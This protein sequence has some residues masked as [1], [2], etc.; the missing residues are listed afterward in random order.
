MNGSLS[1]WDLDKGEVVWRK[2]DAHKENPV[3]A[4]DITPDG[5][6]GLSAGRE[7]KLR[8]WRLPAVPQTRA[9]EQPKAGREGIVNPKK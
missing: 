8:Y 6:Y 3:M 7:A 1:L 4:V 5:R 2:L 9:G